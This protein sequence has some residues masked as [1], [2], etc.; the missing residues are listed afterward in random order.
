MT[1]FC[2][3]SADLKLKSIGQ[4]GLKLRDPPASQVLGL[5]VCASTPR[6]IIYFLIQENN[7]HSEANKSDFAL[8]IQAEQYCLQRLLLSVN[9]RGYP[10][11]KQWRANGSRD[12][13]R[14]ETSLR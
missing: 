11:Q 13:I 5:K 8:K 6:K 2:V 12:G 7:K 14:A 9:I 10:T 4:A 3:A 1:G